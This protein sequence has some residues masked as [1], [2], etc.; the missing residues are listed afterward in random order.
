MALSP[1]DPFNTVARVR[2][3]QIIYNANDQYI[4]RSL[5][6]YGEFSGLETSVF[7]QILSAGQ[8]VVEAG[9]NIGVHSLFFARKVG[10]TGRVLAFEPQRMAFQ[11]LCGNMALNSITNAFCWNM[12][13]GA[14]SGEMTVPCLDPRQPTNFG[15]I[16]LGTDPDD[17][18]VTVTTID[19]LNL[20]QC[21][22]I[23]VDVEGMEEEVLRGAVQTIEKHKPLLY[24]E[25]DQVEREASLI[26]FVDSLGY[27]MFWHLP[28]LFNPHNFRKHEEN[29]FGEIVSRNILCMEK[30]VEHELT[31]FEP[32]VVPRAA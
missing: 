22:L 21:D 29:V 14:T 6:L 7:D 26:Q 13:L 30:A 15:G 25:C 23:K 31:G 11:T 24:V 5:E 28:P 16:A 2:Y 17:E 32:V 8:V 12:A 27:E 10:E 9:A 3:G 1:L 19:A 20:P 18:I 4:G